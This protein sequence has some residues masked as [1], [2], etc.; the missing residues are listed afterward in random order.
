MTTSA[1]T[2]LINHQVRLASR[3]HGLPTRANWSF[4]EEAVTQPGL[5]GVLV[6]TL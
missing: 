6:K 1:T 4:T 2:A 5:G 3:P